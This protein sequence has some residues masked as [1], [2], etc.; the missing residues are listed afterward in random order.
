MAEERRCPMCGRPN[1]A[2]AEVCRHCGARLTMLGESA[3]QEALQDA[4][5]TA[6][7]AEPEDT[8]AER[9]PASED[10]AWLRSM[11][12]GSEETEAAE[13]ASLPETERTG[14]PAWAP[15]GSDELRARL[16]D[17]P[18][19][20]RSAAEEAAAETPAEPAPRETGPSTDWLPP[21][22]EEEA[23]AAEAEAAAAAETP[24]EPAPRE[25]GSSTDWLP[26]WAEEE[27]PAA[28][29]EAAAASAAGNAAETG[30]I[31]PWLEEE[32]PSPAASTEAEAESE[33]APTAAPSTDDLL[34]RIRHTGEL[35]L[36]A[37]E[38]EALLEAQAEEAPP[39][40]ADLLE[41]ELAATEPE[42]PAEETLDRAEVP[43][44]LRQA[45]PPS[46]PDDLPTA[47]DEILQAPADSEDQDAPEALVGLPDILPAARDIAHPRVRSRAPLTLRLT[48]RQEQRAKWLL[49]LLQAEKQPRRV[50]APWQSTRV[51]WLRF[52]AGVFLVLAWVLQPHLPGRLGQGPTPHP[53]WQAAY[54]A[55]EGLPPQAPV[56]LVVDASWATAPEMRRIVE[57]VW[58]HLQQRQ[59]QVLQV[60]TVPW[61]VGLFTPPAEAN[62]PWYS[63]GF[64][65]GGAVWMAQARQTLPYALGRS[66]TTWPPPTLPAWQGVNSLAQTA[67]IIVVTDDPEQARLWAEQV[68]PALGGSSGLVFVLSSQA[69]P[70]SEPYFTVPG[71]RGAVV[72]VEAA[73]AYGQQIGLDTG[74]TQA[75]W[76]RQQALWLMGWLVMVGLLAL[77]AS[78]RWLS[79][80][81]RSKAS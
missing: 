49:E 80:R 26:P 78:V 33:A 8:S 53:A 79:R 50:G 4:F 20:A 77:A 65:S 72:G 52:L 24:A 67:L 17:W 69:G 10:T 73:L 1:P 64:V 12:A 9:R 23:P 48:R 46:T 62:V 25:T 59:A 58:Q 66:V 81:R 56:L 30:W 41:E 68:A 47:V 38:L 61:G 75:L 39:E 16:E 3:D 15:P 28:E 63:V 35:A 45:A 18:A 5:G 76:A 22:A 44:W 11:F 29:A 57:P 32:S 36:S 27:A 34:E 40:P 60:S 14:E 37:E 19:A 2:D 13:E 21:W 54:T 55:L 70:W 7:F 43:E 42:S 31:P 6:W 74:A 71:V 51:G